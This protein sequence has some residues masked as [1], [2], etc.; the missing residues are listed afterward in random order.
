MPDEE[1]IPDPRPA[2]V[3]QTVNVGEHAH[4]GLQGAILKYAQASIV[5]LFLLIY[6]WMQWHVI[7]TGREDRQEDR[8]LF[9]ESVK[10]LQ[11]DASLR[12]RQINEEA[13]RRAQD[14]LRQL[15]D[16]SERREKE[17]DDAQNRRAGELRGSMDVNTATL[18]QLIEELKTSRKVGVVRP[19]AALPKPPEP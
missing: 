18:R 19:D 16:D 10:Q 4:G 13:A 1:I 7:S 6:S 3:Q 9:R 12:V 5:T 8:R 2:P 14:Y 15:R 11:D 17:L